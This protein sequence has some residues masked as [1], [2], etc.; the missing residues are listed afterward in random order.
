MSV[1]VSVRVRGVHVSE[2]VCM[3]GVWWCVCVC[4]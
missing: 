4:V 1:S 3:C 2:R